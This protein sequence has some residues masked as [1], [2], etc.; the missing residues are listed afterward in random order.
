M[1]GEADKWP[2]DAPIVQLEKFGKTGFNAFNCNGGS[3][4]YW[5]A[6]KT[7]TGTKIIDAHYF[8]INSN[9]TATTGEGSGSSMRRVRCA[10][11]Y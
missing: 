7:T 1:A 6:E 3:I 10:K 8:I 11:V 9:G 4:S 2:D 5:A